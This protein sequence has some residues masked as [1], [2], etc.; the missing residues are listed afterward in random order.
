MPSS[1]SRLSWPSLRSHSLFLDFSLSSPPLCRS[2]P[3]AKGAQTAQPLPADAPRAR[4]LE[5]SGNVTHRAGRFDPH[6][7]P[8]AS[9][10]WDYLT[11]LVRSL[12]LTFV[13]DLPPA[14]EPFALFA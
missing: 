12:I 5:L 2:D 13:F 10:F 1:S 6:S 3:A 8:H 11:I 7:D 14:F 9:R 4:R